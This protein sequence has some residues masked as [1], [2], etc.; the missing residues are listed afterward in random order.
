M[1]LAVLGGSYNPVHI[2]HLCLAEAV[3]TSL[4]YDRVV[5]IPAF[6]S[7]FKIGAEGASVPDRMDMLAASITADPRLTIDDCEITREGVS[8]TIDTLKD[9][10]S[11]YEPDG[12]P[13]LILGDDLA[14]TFHK[15]RSP[16]EI[17]ELSDIIIAR[18][19]SEA[20]RYFAG[21][22]YAELHGGNAGETSAAGAFSFPFTA[23]NN[24]IISVSSAE[25]RKNIGEGAA[26]RY[27]IPSGARY[28]IQDRGL[29]GFSTGGENVSRS[30]EN[31]SR[32]DSSPG[33]GQV[34][35]GLSSGIALKLK[36][37]GLTEIIGRIENDVRKILDA[38]RFIHCRNTAVL[39]WDLCRRFGLDSQKGYLAGI[40]HDMCKGLEEKELI[41]LANRDGGGM[42][43]LEQKKPGLLHGRA[44]A[45]FV[46]RKY[47]ITDKDILD[48]IR[49]HTTGSSN[50]SA[51]ARVVYIADKIEVSRS[52]IDPA[53]REMRRSAD[54]DTLFAAVLDNTV[55]HLKSRNMDI[56]YGT[57]RLLAAMSK[58]SNL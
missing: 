56:S 2:G 14:S 3:L 40:A 30:S 26:W 58:R 16:E 32:E 10:I 21:E 4:C 27:L 5:L 12:K 53:L 51:I 28:I 44:A 41:R 33:S 7:P 29:Y 9:I 50:M 15:W 13:G 22:R 47:G 45:V 49:H 36:E 17:V 57:R 24:E 55:A 52:G 31:V 43:K 37:S 54:F 42:S 46:K 38:R 39:S 34:K 6:Q 8:Y 35:K 19:L 11:R 25:L 48:A 1:K 20:S 23:L 18:R